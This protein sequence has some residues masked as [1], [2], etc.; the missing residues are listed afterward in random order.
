MAND[1]IIQIIPCNFNNGWVECFGMD[2]CFYE[3][4]SAFG[5]TE[6][7]KV[8]TLAM[9]EDDGQLEIVEGNLEY[10]LK[11]PEPIYSQ[12]FK[13]KLQLWKLE[14]EAKDNQRLSDKNETEGKNNG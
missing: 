13:A 2:V 4:V 3:R 11:Q 9:R 12:R 1:K 6:S 5:L 10:S 14:R 8:V 7:G